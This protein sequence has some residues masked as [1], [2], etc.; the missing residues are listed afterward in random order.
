M[1]SASFRERAIRMTIAGLTPYLARVCKHLKA[2]LVR[3]IYNNPNVFSTRIHRNIVIPD[4]V[5]LITT[6]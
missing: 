2:H 6:N 1:E 3:Q 5:E 4:I